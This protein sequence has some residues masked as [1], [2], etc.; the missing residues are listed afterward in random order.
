MDI[1]SFDRFYNTNPKQFE[2]NP[3]NS[4]DRALLR[5][6]ENKIKILDNFLFSGDIISD[7]N[8]FLEITSRN[9]NYKKATN[10]QKEE[11]VKNLESI[12]SSLL[13]NQDEKINTTNTNEA[14]KMFY[15]ELPKAE[16]N[17]IEKLVKFYQ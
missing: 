1:N 13:K 12:L 14:N 5:D 9:I 4:N 11:L 16:I 7:Y 15:E 8:Y 2:H 3:I 17:V 6:A 10:E